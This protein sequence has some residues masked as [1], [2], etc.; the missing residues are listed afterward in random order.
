MEPKKPEVSFKV[1]TPQKEIPLDDLREAVDAVDDILYGIDFCCEPQNHCWDDCTE[2]HRY[3]L[4][5]AEDALRMAVANLIQVRYGCRAFYSIT[6]EQEARS[7]VDSL[8]YKV[9]CEQAGRTHWR[10][11][12]AFVT[13]GRNWVDKEAGVTRHEIQ[14]VFINPLLERVTA[15]NHLAR[16]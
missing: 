14:S 13:V 10:T 8:L 15:E 5:D 9:Y 1:T 2:S 16:P 6:T 3:R 11:T 12:R 7:W 4:S